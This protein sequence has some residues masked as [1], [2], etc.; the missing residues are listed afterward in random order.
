MH[1]CV[2]LILLFVY[3]VRP[4]V[5]CYVCASAFSVEMQLCN[6]IF[7]R[8]YPFGSS[9]MKWCYIES[10]LE[11]YSPEKDLNLGPF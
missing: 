9:S 6:K 11:Y 5:I 10:N 7:L 1:V 4:P 3:V 8:Q 2:G